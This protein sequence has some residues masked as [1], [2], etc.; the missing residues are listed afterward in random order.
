MEG[1]KEERDPEHWAAWQNWFPYLAV[2]GSEHPED[3]IW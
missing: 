2:L 3:K 1:A